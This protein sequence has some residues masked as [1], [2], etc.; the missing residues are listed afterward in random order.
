[1]SLFDLHG[2]YRGNSAVTDDG[3]YAITGLEPGD[4][5]LMTV[6]DRYVDE[7]FRDLVM[8]LDSRESWRQAETV[9][10]I[11]EQMTASIDFDLQTGAELSGM[12]LRDDGSSPVQGQTL[13]FVFT[14]KDSPLPVYTVTRDTEEG[15]FTITVPLAG[16]FKVSVAADTFMQTWYPDKTNWRDGQVITIPEFSSR[17]PISIL[18]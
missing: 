16:E 9:T 13:T 14:R 7:I 6:S 8:P 1:M 18:P 2:Y 12:V 5:Y 17:F 10:V 3:S 4:Y 15:F 11:Q